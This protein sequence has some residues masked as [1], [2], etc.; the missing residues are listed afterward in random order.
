[1]VAVDESV[2]VNEEVAVDDTDVVA[3]DVPVVD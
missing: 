1:V 3:V 2:V